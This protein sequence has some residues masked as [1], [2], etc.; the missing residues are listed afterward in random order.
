M[1]N[2][3]ADKPVMKFFMEPYASAMEEFRGGLQA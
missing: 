1:E 3:M 2:F